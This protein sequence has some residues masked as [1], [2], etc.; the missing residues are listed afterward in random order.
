MQHPS[1]KIERR[2]GGLN[3]PG[4]R[5]AATCDDEIKLTESAQLRQRAW[6]S[7]AGLGYARV[8]GRLNFPDCRFPA[9]YNDEMKL[10]ESAQLPKRG[11][12]TVAGLGYARVGSSAPCFSF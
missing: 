3:P 11:W 8:G 4:S 7:L 2:V 10:T 9:T 1:R 5:F 6:P 12:P